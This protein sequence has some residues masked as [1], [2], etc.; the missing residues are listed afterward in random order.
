MLQLVTENKEPTVI[1]AGDYMV[2]WLKDSTVGFKRPPDRLLFM[3]GFCDDKRILRC[4]KH[5]ADS[6]VRLVAFACGLNVV[7]VK[8]TEEYLSYRFQ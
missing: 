5:D 6:V 7:M 4:D 3:V 8:E 1:Q 2:F